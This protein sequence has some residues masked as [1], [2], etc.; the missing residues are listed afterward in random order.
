[1][2]NLVLGLTWSV[3]IRYTKGDILCLEDFLNFMTLPFKLSLLSLNGGLCI[4]TA[5][6]KQKILLGDSFQWDVEIPEPALAWLWQ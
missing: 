2:P 5:F 3:E 1:M 6:K 4:R